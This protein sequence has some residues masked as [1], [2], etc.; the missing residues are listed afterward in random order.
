MGDATPMG[1]PFGRPPNKLLIHPM[2]DCANPTGSSV[3]KPASRFD[4]ADFFT[5]D[6]QAEIAKNAGRAR[7]RKGPAAQAKKEPA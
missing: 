5:A 4:A 2:F 3:L 1:H 6:Q 7:W